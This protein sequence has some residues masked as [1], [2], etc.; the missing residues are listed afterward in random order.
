MK[1]GNIEE[2][3]WEEN[4]NSL[5][6][7]ST[8]IFNEFKKISVPFM[9]EEYKKANIKPSYKFHSIECPSKPKGRV[10]L[11]MKY[12]KGKPFNFMLDRKLYF[13]LSKLW[14]N[15]IGPKYKHY[16]FKVLGPSAKGYSCDPGEMILVI[17]TIGKK[18]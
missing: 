2:M 11:G 15:T 4:L 17:D 12:Y 6:K 7:L 1:Q 13:G 8:P 18:K 16:S 10:I 14:K 3:G 5:T 9:Q